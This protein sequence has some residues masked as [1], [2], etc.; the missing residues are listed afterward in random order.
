MTLRIKGSEMPESTTRVGFKAMG[1]QG[2]ENK[3]YDLSNV[4]QVSGETIFL[5]MYNTDYARA[6]Y[7]NVGDATPAVVNNDVYF[8]TENGTIFGV[9][10]GNWKKSLIVG[11][12][13]SWELE[14]VS[15]ALE[16]TDQILAA[17]VTAE[18]IF[19]RMY[20]TSY[21]RAGYAS[22]GDTTPAVVDN[23]VYF[24]TG[25]GTIFGLTVTNWLKTLIVGKDGA[26]A[27]EFVKS[28]IDI[29]SVIN[30]T[31]L[32]PP[33]E[34]YHTFATAISSSS[35]LNEKEGMIIRYEESDGVW[36]SF[37]LVDLAYKLYRKGWKDLDA[38]NLDYTINT[39]MASTAP[40]DFYE[41]VDCQACRVKIS[42]GQNVQLYGYRRGVVRN[43]DGN[44]IDGYY[45]N[46]SDI[47]TV[48]TFVAPADAAYLDVTAF[49]ADVNSASVVIS[50]PLAPYMSEEEVKKALSDLTGGISFEG[51]TGGE[52]LVIQDQLKKIV[53]YVGQD[54]S[55]NIP[56]LNATN[57]DNKIAE[58]E[59]K[60]ISLQTQTSL[61]SPTTVAVNNNHDRQ[62]N[63]VLKE[64]GA[65]IQEGVIPTPKIMIT[66]TD[67]DGHDYYQRSPETY[68]LYPGG[69]YSRLFPVFDKKGIKGNI[70]YI[71]NNWEGTASHAYN[72]ARYLQDI[73]GWEVLSHSRNHDYP[74]FN[75]EDTV[76][77][78]L[79]HDGTIE[80][81]DMDEAEQYMSEQWGKQQFIDLGFN[82]KNACC[83]GGG[84]T[85]A[86]LRKIQQAEG[87]RCVL[88]N[89]GYSKTT[90]M[91]T[92][93][94]A[95]FGVYRDTILETYGNGTVTDYLKAGT[96]DLEQKLNDCKQKIDDMVAD[97]GGGWL[98]IITHGVYTHYCNYN[99][100]HDTV[101]YPAAW[102][103][104]VA[105]QTEPGNYT[106]P[107]IPSDWEPA[108]NTALKMIWD[109]IDYAKA[110]GV[111]FV[112]VDEAVDYWGN[113]VNVGDFTWGKRHAAFEPFK[114]PH[115][116]VG[117]N[118]SSRYLN[119]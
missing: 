92:P 39:G 4:S 17:Q 77:K 42:E 63:N 87:Y 110:Q 64:K 72:E 91:N 38:E 10:V 80:I 27:I 49:N 84:K 81:T 30:V 74:F 23:S 66:M 5:R 112:T 88:S 53:T 45:Y 44:V 67:D 43:I 73:H 82:V 114:S 21:N 97:G 68:G 50:A 115:Y 107:G 13:G 52:L 71:I 95:Q 104:P 1:V 59:R 37:Q 31:D 105:V 55:V 62:I 119:F 94:L 76:E 111:E 116:V 69:F 78:Y 15:S 48:S 28:P 106:D 40:Y 89:N 24:P 14:I 75:L 18:S 98:D 117:V 65:Y 35:A 90:L 19:L 11:K 22:V 79:K 109:F 86:R 102:R 60:I 83:F 57:I 51:K 54:G 70:A 3:V 46:T 96:D 29:L 85:T 93:P 26:W 41:N 108:P 47:N 25:N 20:N 8:P 61:A 99:P 9:T 34:G 113:L 2:G 58:L 56:T 118:G 12:N 16:I 36:K 6:G 103:V 32:F 101:D 100:D 33:T 7:A